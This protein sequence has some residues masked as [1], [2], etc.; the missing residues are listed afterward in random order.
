MTARELRTLARDAIA[1]AGAR[2]FVRFAPEGA[3]ALLITD[4]PRFCADGGQRTE[5]SDALTSRGF[6]CREDGGLLLITP[7]DALL[8][9]LG[10]GAASPRSWDWESPL[11]PVY[12]LADRWLRVGG[13]SCEGMC[14]KSMAAAVLSASA[15]ADAMP[16]L[17]EAGRRLA[18]ETARLLWRPRAQVLAGLGALRARAA[19][20][21]RKKDVSGL[22]LCGGMLMEWIDEQT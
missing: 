4:A 6:S 15:E 1:Q 10:Q 14:V 18:L 9:R 17:T 8:S 12:A 11:T 3:D 5:L 21:Q 2:G 22:R 13:A 7:E 20:M 16:P 19:I